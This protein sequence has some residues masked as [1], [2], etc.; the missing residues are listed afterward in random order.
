[1]GPGEG[2]LHARG[3]A[4]VDRHRVRAA[5]DDLVRF[6]ERALVAVPEGELRAGMREALGDGE[7][8]A[9]GAAGHD[10][11]A[12]FQ[13]EG[14]HG[15]RIPSNWSDHLTIAAQQS[16]RPTSVPE[17]L[18]PMAA[19]KR[20]R[21]QEWFGREGKMG[22]IYR[23]WMKNRGIPQDQFD[24]RPVIG[25]CNTYSELTPCNSHFRTSAEHV[26]NGVLEAG[27]FPL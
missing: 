4:H 26:K 23:S 11:A 25:I 9:G 6:L 13:V 21:S 17:I 16:Y 18:P 10:G 2:A 19:P 24:G 8:D 15:R 14:V 5:G 12:A 27:G 22:F 1:E 3:V 20:R 7:S